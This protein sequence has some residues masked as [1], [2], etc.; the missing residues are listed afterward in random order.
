MGQQLVNQKTEGEAAVLLQNVNAQIQLH[1]AR[2]NE[3]QHLASQQDGS[4]QLEQYKRH[5]RSHH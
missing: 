2:I 1:Q 3:L 5:K 4:L